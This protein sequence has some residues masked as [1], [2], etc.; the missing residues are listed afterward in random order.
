MTELLNQIR[1]EYSLLL[2]CVRKGPE[3]ER[4]G[5]IR[6]LIREGI[7][8]PYL[9]EASSRHG[10]SPLLYKYFESDPVEGVPKDIL[11]RLRD[12]FRNNVLWNLARTRE[13]LRLLD[14]F[15]QEGI[16]AIPY[17]GPV[18]SVMAYGDLSLRQF[19]DLD[20]FVRRDEVRRVMDLLSNE[21]YPVDFILTP[22]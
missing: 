21:G 14:L 4:A 11:D 16:Q 19:D 20:I 1:P 2:W 6:R 10:L 22:R 12:R 17:K 7:D 8:W 13:L 5:Q 3:E 9:I 15:S 18:L